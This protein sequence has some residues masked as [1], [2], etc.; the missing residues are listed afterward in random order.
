MLTS[1]DLN[2]IVAYKTILLPEKSEIVNI[3]DCYTDA[4]KMLEAVTTD[5]ERLSAIE[6]I[7]TMFFL[8]KNPMRTKHYINKLAKDFKIRKEYFTTQIKLLA[9]EQ[10][11]QTKEMYGSEDAPLIVR[12]ENFINKNFEIRYNEVSNQFESKRVDEDMWVIMNENIILREMRHNF[13]NYSAGSLIELLKSDFIPRINPIKSY[14]KN[15]PPWDG[16]DHISKLAQ[17]ILL[18]DKSA[19]E[20]DRFYRMFKKMF[21]RSIACSFEF[22]F[23]KQAFILVH[24]IQN[25]GK[26][27]FIR[28][29]CPNILKDYYA[30]NIST[31]KDSLIALTE[32]FIINLDELSTL[33]KFE[34]N[35]LKSVMS[36]D[37]IKVRIPYERRPAILQ[38]RCNFIGSTNRQEFL[39][40]ETGN[41]RWVC[42][43]IERIDWNYSKDLNIDN[44]WAQAYHLFDKSQYNYQLTPDEI[45]ENETANQQFII[46]TAEMELLQKHYEP[47]KKDDWGVL[48]LSATDIANELNKKAPNIKIHNAVLGK[49]LKLLGYER[50]EKYEENKGYQIYGYYI[51]EKADP[52]NP[53]L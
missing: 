17:Y 22:A 24:E 8:A 31:D 35:A 40:D 29:L 36:K 9:D 42:F 28:W 20:T 43:L 44:V 41:V 14:F 52:N 30:E 13:F 48:F 21:V 1:A 3:D 39:N 49:Y 4:C 6:K 23:N 46:R 26:T 16:E 5:D 37:K 34:I 19:H 25:S 38:R 53:I 2:P 32:N 15:L 50:S 18:A 27:T 12:I 45:R 33:S 11:Q 47:A 7:S 51:K 10:K